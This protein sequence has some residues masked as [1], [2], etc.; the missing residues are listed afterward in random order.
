MGCNPIY[1]NGMDLD[2]HDPKGPYAKLKENKSVED[3]ELISTWGIANRNAWSDWRREWI[4]R[5]FNIVNDRAKNV[6]VNIYNLK[7]N[8]WYKIF[9]PGIIG[10]N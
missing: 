7:N 2:Y 4:V 3:S 8:A 10:E 5:D 1:I 9:K 6:N